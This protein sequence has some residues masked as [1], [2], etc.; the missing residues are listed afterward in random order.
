MAL[1]SPGVSQDTV[2]AEL[3]RAVVTVRVLPDT[4]AVGQPFVVTM[5]VVPPER[6]SASPPAL[7]DTGGFVEP[8]DPAQRTRRSDTLFVRYRFLAWQPGVL[9]IPFG[10]V[11][12]TSGAERV[13]QPVDVRV[14]VASVLP[15]DS[16]ARLPRPVRPLIASAA[17]W[18]MLWWR[19]VLAGVLLTTLGLLILAW[20][21]VP[22]RA[23]TSPKT[24]PIDTA[25]AALTRLRARDLPAIG[26]SA[27][28]V[29]LAAEILRRYLQSVEPTLVMALSTIELCDRAESVAHVDV[30]ALREVL[31]TVDAVRFS[32]AT[33]AR[34]DALDLVQRIEALIVETDRR[35]QQPLDEAA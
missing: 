11:V 6:Y 28:H 25:V 9:S 3:P 12:L 32:G 26:E 29:V 14:V 15:R 34:L 31:V 17:P 1:S 20:L 2:A 4:V 10:S 21:R 5:R 27:R 30:A 33:L 23:R 22:R 7:P 24:A 13:E 8:L 19:W 35:R 16:S 18:W